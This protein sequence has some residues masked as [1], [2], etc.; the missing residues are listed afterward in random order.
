M[1][2]LHRYFN[3]ILI[4]PKE[5]NSF[6]FAFLILKHASVNKPACYDS[7]PCAVADRLGSIASKSII[8]KIYAYESK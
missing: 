1:S 5:L 4:R 2:Q 3:V 7:Y 8:S 6:P